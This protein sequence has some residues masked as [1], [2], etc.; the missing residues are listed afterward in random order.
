MA[1]EKENTLGRTK[2]LLETFPALRGEISYPKEE[3]QKK[4]LPTLRLGLLL[5][6]L[7][8]LVVVSGLFIYFFTTHGIVY[9]PQAQL[10]W[11]ISLFY[12]FFFHRLLFRK[13]VALNKNLTVKFDFL[14]FSSLLIL[15][16]ELFGGICHPL[17]LFWPIIIFGFTLAL[18]PIFA[19]IILGVELTVVFSFIYLE[20][21][22]LSF[23]Q[24]NPYLFYLELIF[25]LSV[26]IFS[27]FFTKHYFKIQKEK[28]QFERLVD[29]LSADKS[30]VEAILES[31]GDGVFVVD[32]N[33]KLI[34]INNSAK[35][36]VKLGKRSVL[37]RFYGD[38]FKL[39]DE[40]GNP[41]NYEI[42]CPIQK[43][44]SE[45]RS[46]MRDD[47][48][49]Q[50]LFGK[51][52]ALAFYA[53]PISDAKGDIIGGIAVLRDITHEKEMERMKYEFVSIATHE[54]STPIAA[55]EG[56]LSM[57]LDEEIG[58]VDEK[59]KSL[60]KN[61]YEGSKRLARLVKDLLNVSKIEEGKMTMD[62]KPINL[63]EVIE[64]TVYELLPVAE[65]SNLY[66]R[67]QKTLK[68]IPRAL[69]DPIRIREILSNLISNAIK[70]TEK[71]GIIVSL[72]LRAKSPELKAHGP[73]PRA[74]SQ[75]IIV[76]VSD[77]GVGIAKEYLPYLFQKFHQVDTS[78]TRR[79]QGTG[80][81]LY[82]CKSIVELHGGKI[83][84]E[85]EVGKGSQFRFTL[86]VAKNY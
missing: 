55:I 17:A 58:K 48:K 7:A 61:A 65:K 77:S 13:L 57:I 56:H 25:L 43:A 59:A 67:Y 8:W 38:I 21:S 62:I 72:G 32:Q 47:L 78:A 79:A 80:L 19:F 63:E 16:V 42:D 71:G 70:F 39:E 73:G 12:A 9:K 83:W 22:Q 35:R 14:I 41:L 40:E 76:S 3:F 1:K 46:V 50:T 75:E 44:I 27:Y 64:D 53:A 66:L 51:K 11:L 68:K 4:I 84:A 54:L 23:I 37:G 29:Q 86:P 69:G 15:A 81:G 2:S 45:K 18:G 6:I 30:K 31:M 5:E 33:K 24:N 49:T 85:S 26:G 60:L 20:P 82:I 52:I 28:L 74:Q 36:L 10:I 34:L